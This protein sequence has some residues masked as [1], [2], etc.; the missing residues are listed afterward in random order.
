MKRASLELA[1][2]QPSEGRTCWTLRLLAEKSRVVLDTPIGK[3]AIRDIKKTE[4]RPRL[5][6]YEMPYNPQ[7]PVICMDEKP[8]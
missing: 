4:L 3:E 6:V 7:R 5:N 1:R 8:Y 2:S